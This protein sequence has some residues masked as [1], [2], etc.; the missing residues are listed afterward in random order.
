MIDPAAITEEVRALERLDLEGLRSEWRRRYGAPPKLRSVD[1]LAR[2]LAWRIQATA[3]GGLDAET[4]RNLRRTGAPARERQLSPGSLIV[5]E[6]QG[7]HHEVTVGEGAYRYEGQSY[8][9]L[10]A[11]AHAITGVKWNGPRFFGLRAGRAT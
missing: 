1:L 3:F 7:R 5:R 2:L 8:R 10:S 11:V 6:W 4:R 9:S